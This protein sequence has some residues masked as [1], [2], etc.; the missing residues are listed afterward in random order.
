MLVV[1]RGCVALTIVTDQLTEGGLISGSDHGLN[2]IHWLEGLWDHPSL[3]EELLLQ[4]G[5][6]W[7]LV[8]AML[9][10]LLLW[11]ASTPRHGT[12]SAQ[13]LIR[14]ALATNTWSG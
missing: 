14:A 8:I 6:F 12:D 4:V 13:S 3:L 10:Q 2:F 1:N 5:Q 9:T 7:V 11:T